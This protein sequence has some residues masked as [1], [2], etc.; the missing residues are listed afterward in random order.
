MLTDVMVMLRNVDVTSHI[1][2]IQAR[3]SNAHS[4]QHKKQSYSLDVKNRQAQ[5]LAGI[6][7]LT[8]K[9]K[10]QRLELLLKQQYFKY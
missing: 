10:Q 1:Y 7:N 9:E 5:K 4:I 6:L 8:I 3:K 2:K